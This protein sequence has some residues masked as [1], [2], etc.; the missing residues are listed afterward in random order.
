MKAAVLVLIFG[1]V[2]HQTYGAL[3]TRAQWG[4]RAP[5]G[6]SKFSGVIPYVVIHHSESPGVCTTT[7]ACKAAMRSMQNYHMNSNGWAD[8]GY[9]FAIGGD[10][11]TYEGRGYNVVGAHAP[12]YNSQSIGLLLIGDF[13][14]ANAPAKMITAAKNFISSA[15]S[16]GK[17]SSSYKLIGH[18]QAVST[19]CP[20][21]KLYAEIKTW[22]RYTAKP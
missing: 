3:I 10:G 19:D 14:K 6:T 9:S 18:R 22:P 16:A 8:I 17:L 1:V 2:L 20:G 15:V 13:R 12:G 21:D 7:D 11:N 5:T 4:A